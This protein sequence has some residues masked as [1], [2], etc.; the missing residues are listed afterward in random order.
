MN[1]FD[2]SFTKIVPCKGNW[3]MRTSNTMNIRSTVSDRSA[4]ISLIQNDSTAFRASSRILNFLHDDVNRSPPRIEM[5]SFL[6]LFAFKPY[7]KQIMTS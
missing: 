1:I 6:K 2:M 3:T 7:A 5:N 4:V